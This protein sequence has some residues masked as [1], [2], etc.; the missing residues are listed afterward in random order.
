MRNT[1]VVSS[2][3]FTELD[4]VAERVMSEAA[5]FSPAYNRDTRVPVW[6]QMPVTFEARTMKAAG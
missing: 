3:G 2:S 6:I 5:R 1:R 4:Q